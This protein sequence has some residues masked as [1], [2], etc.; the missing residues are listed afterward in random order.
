MICRALV[1]IVATAGLGCASAPRFRNQP[2][3]WQVSD[4]ES[5]AEPAK[6]VFVIAAYLADA[7]ALRQL[8]RALELRSDRPALDTNALDEVPDS[9]WFQNRIGRR[10]LSPNEATMGPGITGPPELPLTVLSSKDGGGNPGFVARDKRGE[11]F[12]VKFDTKQNPELQ[13]AAD[14][15][16]SRFLWAIGYNVPEDHVFYFRRADVHVAASAK[17]VNAGGEQ[18][19]FRRHALDAMLKDVPP[20]ADGSLRASASRFLEGVPKG[21]FGMEGARDDDPNDLIAHERRRVLRGLFVFCAWLDHTDMKEDNTV[22]MYVSER[23]RRFLRHHLVDFGEALGGHAAEKGR[24]E[25]GFEHWWDW[26]AQS[27]ALV[28]FGL[29]KRPW[30]D[31]RP[32]PYASVGSLPTGDFEPNKWREAYPFWPFREMDAADAYWAAKVV[33]RFDR[34]ML[35]AIVK[36]GKLSDPRAARYLVDALLVRQRK[37]GRAFLEAVTPLDDFHADR[38][39]LCATDLGTRYGLAAGG[40][41]ERVDDDDNAIERLAVRADGRVCL[42]KLPASYTVLRLRVRRG[43]AAKPAMQ[44]HVMG[45]TRVLGIIRADARVP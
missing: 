42:S 40:I 37:I 38:G 29:W 9:S 45:G 18:E 16:V 13:S 35:E 20:R 44:V 22:D 32:S 23:G 43:A 15:I 7:L 41:V 39:R 30:E 11:R 19:P 1:L 5:I 12:V 6:R 27:K 26:P 34:K 4:D 31:R 3:V 10:R 25:D 21:G 14:A 33:M 17:F 36:T 28:T 8:E 24:S 2:I